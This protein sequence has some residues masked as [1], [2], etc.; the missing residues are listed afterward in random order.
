MTLIMTMAKLH[1]SE[2]V[3]IRITP[4]SLVEKGRCS[5]RRLWYPFRAKG[6]N[7]FSR[8]KVK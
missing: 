1:R 3:T 8:K 4:F 7:Y 2:Y 5:V 6:R